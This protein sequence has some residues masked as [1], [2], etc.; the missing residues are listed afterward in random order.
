MDCE[1]TI[2]IL[3]REDLKNFMNKWE[4]LFNKVDYSNV[5]I[6]SANALCQ[7][8]SVLKHTDYKIKCGMEDK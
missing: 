8:K 6:A 5:P 4:M 3:F 7:M 2:F 1:E